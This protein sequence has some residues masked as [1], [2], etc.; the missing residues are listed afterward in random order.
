[1]SE[2]TWLRAVVKE[3]DRT[4]AVLNRKAEGKLVYPTGMK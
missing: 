4:S 1:M 2:I 3:K